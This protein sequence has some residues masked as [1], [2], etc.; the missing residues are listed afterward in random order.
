MERKGSAEWKGGLKDGQG[1][2]SSESGT[3]KNVN[4]SFAKRFGDEP[5]TNRLADVDRDE[6]A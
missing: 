3:L 4:Y 5:G 2:L 6:R 1:M